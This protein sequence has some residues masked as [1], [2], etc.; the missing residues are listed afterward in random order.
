[1]NWLAPL[2]HLRRSRQPAPRTNREQTGRC[3]TTKDESGRDLMEGLEPRKLASTVGE[4][5]LFHSV[6]DSSTS[7]IVEMGNPTLTLVRAEG[8]LASDDAV[9]DLV[10]RGRAAAASGND[11][12]LD[13]SGVVR[14]D[15]R[16]V[17]GIVALKSATRSR[18]GRIHLQ[19]S[20]VVT[21][22]LDFCRLE[23]SL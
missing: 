4:A 19:S 5:P 18:G 22:W 21:A 14:A 12:L 11:L 23:G 20:P 16:L 2:R 1:M 7:V 13:L 15:T 3:T 6:Q 10:R 9:Q 8:D 17:A